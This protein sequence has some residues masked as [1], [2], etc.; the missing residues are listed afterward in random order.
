MKTEFELIIKCEKLERRLASLE[1]TVEEHLKN[2]DTPGKG[3]E[4]LHR[5]FNNP[6]FVK[7]LERSLDDFKNGRV[8]VFEDDDSP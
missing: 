6:S 2:T 4:V 7:S 8:E 3:F 1:K 5:P